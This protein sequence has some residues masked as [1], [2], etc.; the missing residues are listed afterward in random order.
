MNQNGDC[1]AILEDGTI[2]YPISYA[3]ASLDGFVSE[4]DGNGKVRDVAIVALASNEKEAMGKLH[5]YLKRKGA[6]S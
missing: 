3:K 6:T 5:N 2:K 4:I 1:Y